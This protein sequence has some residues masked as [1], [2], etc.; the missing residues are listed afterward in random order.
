MTVDRQAPQAA[1]E[2]I[3]DGAEIAEGARLQG[4]VAGTG[5]AIASLSYQFEGTAAVEVPVNP[6][7]SFDV[8]ISLAGAIEGAQSLTVRAVDVARN[9]IVSTFAVTVLLAGDEDVAPPELSVE[10]TSDTGVDGDGITSEVAVA[11]TVS[12]ESAI[13]LL[14]AGLDGVPVAEFVDISTA[15]NPDGSFALSAEQLLQ[16]FGE[17][18][19]GEHTL[20]FV[21]A[22]EFGNVSAIAA[23]TFTLDTTGPDLTI[24]APIVNA[25][26]SGTA[27]L[28]GS[29]GDTSGPLTAQFSLDGQAATAVDLQSDGSFDVAIGST[30][31]AEGTYQL[32][33]EATDLAGNRSQTQLSFQV[34]PDFVLGPNDGTGFGVRTE[35]A[36]VLDERD[37]FL[38]QTDRTIDL[39]LGEGSRTLRFDLETD[40]DTSATG[41]AVE[42]QLLVY[43]LDPVT[44]A[45]LLGED[46][47]ALFSL[48]GDRADFIPGLVRFDGS[49]VEIDLTR[50]SEV[51]S[52][53]LVVQLVNADGDTGSSVQLSNITVEIDPEGNEAPLFPENDAFATA[54]GELDLSQLTVA[55]ADTIELNFDTVS[56][57]AETGLYQ[58]EVQIRNAG[59]EVLGRRVAIVFSN[60]P[61]GVELLSASGFDGEGNPYI[62]LGNAIFS[63]GLDIGQFSDVVTLSFSNPELLQ[64]DLQATVLSGGANRAPVF[65]PLPPLEVMPGDTLSLPLTATDADGDTVT[66]RIQADGPLPAGTLEGNGRLVFRPQ[67]DE[68][69]SYSFTLVATDG[70]A[71]VRQQVTLDVVADPVT[72]TRFSGTVAST[73]ADPVTG[74]QLRLEGVRVTLGNAETFTS[75]DGSFAIELLGELQGDEILQVHGDSVEGTFPFIAEQ[76]PL[77]LGQEAIAGVNKRHYSTDLSAPDRSCERSGDRSGCG[78]SRHHGGDSGGS[79]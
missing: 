53:Q 1:V 44:G 75:A 33:L 6:D 43:L 25:E 79:G 70:G 23:L 72:T 41:G 14:R 8:A 66:F 22:D 34:S 36:I 73:E 28:I 32:T 67:L 5:S 58:A 50:L 65:E 52:A 24:L 48:A 39:P 29:V 35:D 51:N 4:T 13:T 18:A 64:L 19:D 57:E 11:G 60:L 55:S 15:L 26:H 78:C 47:T 56:L 40:F 2:S 49:A 20:S 42:D 21:A 37:S 76:L 9:E 10:L 30:P 61:E 63:G 71:E 59:T 77:L 62:N 31:L 68:I 17:L 69:G 45:T 27:R 7:G 46:G 74:D 54:A 12:D 38:V 3:A 16:L